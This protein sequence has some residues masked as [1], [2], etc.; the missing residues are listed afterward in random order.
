MEGETGKTL[1]R[2]K[3]YQYEIILEGILVGACAGVAVSLLRI[4]LIKAETLRN[5]VI[6]RA[7]GGGTDLL[8]A[9]AALVLCWGGAA[10][11]LKIAPLCGGSGIPQVKAE[12]LGRVSQDWKK[13]LICKIFGCLAAI[14]GG[15]SLG[16][17]GPSIQIGAM[18]G[19]GVSRIS[20][21]LKTEEKILMT[22]GAGAGLSCAFGAPL[23]GVIFALE[24]LHKSF[25]TEVLLSTMAASVTSN[26]I[27]SEIFGMSPVFDLK[28]SSYLP[29]KYYWIIIIAG[30]FLG[31]FGVVYNK[32]TEFV[33]NLYDKIK[34]PAVRLI[35]PFMLVVPLAVIY[36][37][38]LGSGSELVKR[39]AYGEFILGALAVLLVVKFAFSVISFGS[40]SPGG[41][42][43]PLLVM[44]GVSGG[45][46]AAVT[47]RMISGTLDSWYLDNF[48]MLGMVGFF[49]A[50]VRAPITGV[51]LITEMVG[52]FK[53]FL[54]LCIVALASYITAELLRGEPIYDQL[55]ARLLRKSDSPKGTEG[56]A[57]AEGA[58]GADSEA[59]EKV[60]VDSDVYIGCLMDGKKIETMDLPAGTL[61]VSVLRQG[62]EITPNG[63]TRLRG[64]DKITVICDQRNLYTV[65]RELDRVLKTVAS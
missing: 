61:I 64:G 50:V 36:P 26:F 40:G 46:V 35:I 15:L 1:I 33:Q 22:C 47:G 17:E 25:S 8:V 63:S 29:L 27:S 16:R 14:G 18:A 30:V 37:D 4:G 48:V 6:G 7:Y 65:M 52:D 9:I 23:A 56:I 57:D 28:L 51:I 11:A 54:A 20:G 39:T 2:V 62:V 42:F 43:L 19:K 49:S 21:K 13:V 31:A 58:S 60:L 3:K 55:L 34:T 12:L 5:I 41:I 45:L 32:T 53:S 10:L 44:G 59:F 24:E 38:V